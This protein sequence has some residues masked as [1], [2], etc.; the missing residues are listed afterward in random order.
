MGEIANHLEN[1]VLDSFETQT[2]PDGTPWEP[3]KV[4]T[5]H[6]SYK[7]SKTHTKKGVQTKAFQRYAGKRR[8]L[9]ATGHMQSKLFAKSDNTTATVGF[10]AVSGNFQYPLTHQFGTNKAGRNKKVTIVARPFVPIKENGDLYNGVE[11]ELMNIADEY[12]EMILK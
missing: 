8:M 4:K 12:V 7:G 11:K 3:I 9:R 6:T 1:I 10:N 2:S 5:I